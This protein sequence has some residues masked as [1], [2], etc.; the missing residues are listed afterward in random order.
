MESLTHMKVQ[1]LKTQKKAEREFQSP[2]FQYPEKS[3]QEDYL[4][5]W[6]LGACCEVCGNNSNNC[7]GLP[8]PC[9]QYIDKLWTEMPSKAKHTKSSYFSDDES[10][11][12]YWVLGAIFP[13]ITLILWLVWVWNTPN[14]AKSCLFGTIIGFGARIFASCSF[15]YLLL[16]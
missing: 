15:N 9:T 1:S 10:S 6:E 5:L 2:P 13:I 14:R 16:L 7:I 3:K 4:R 8:D 12:W 11:Y